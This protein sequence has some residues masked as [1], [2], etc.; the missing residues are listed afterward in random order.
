MLPVEI[1]NLPLRQSRKCL[2]DVDT[3]A[4]A[5]VPTHPHPKYPT[6][7][8]SG[9]GGSQV[10]AVA[11]V[12]IR[13]VKG[14]EGP[15]GDQAADIA[16]HD[17]RADGGGAGSVGDDIVG[18]VAVGEGAKGKGAAGDQEGRAVADH[19]VVV[20][21]E[22]DVSDHYQ[23]RAEDEPWHAAVEHPAEEGEEEGEEG[24]DDVG[25]HGVELLAYDAGLRV[26]GADDG[27]G[28]ES[29]TLYGDV[30][31]E[32]DKTGCEGDGAHDA[33]EGL[34]QVDFVQ[35][36]RGG[37]AFGFDACD[38]QVLSLLEPLGRFDMFESLIPFLLGSASARSQ[39]GR[40]W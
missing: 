4:A 6:E 19:G 9:G 40:S 14:Q 30:V 12:K 1:L 31:E 17:V 3:I 34:G 5:I 25:G 11:D 37:D 33:P 23:G 18:N 21:K 13:A 39:D 27:G 26:D 2:V 15:G 16:E 29:E 38:G 28:E 32:E 24:A 36:L 35:E 10:E 7:D 20:G 8:G 22:H